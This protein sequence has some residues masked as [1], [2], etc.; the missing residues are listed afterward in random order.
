MPI[1][2]SDSLP[3]IEIL[4]N[5]NIFV[6]TETRAMTQDIRPLEIAV[7]N[8]MPTK[9]ETETQ[10]LRVLGN[11]PLQINVQFI[12]T[13]THVAR[14]TSKSHIETFYKTFDDIKDLKFDG[15]II[16]GAPVEMLDFEEVDY[17]DELCRIMEWSKENVTSTFHICWGAQAALYYHYGVPKHVVSE[18]VFGIFNHTIP[19]EKKHKILLRGFDDNFFVPHSRHTEVKKSDIEKVSSLE[20]LAE[21]EEAGVYIITDKNER[22][23]FI[24]GHSEYDSDTLQKEYLRDIERGLDIKVPKN[25][26]PDDDPT[27]EPIVKWRSHANLLYS[28]WLNYFV[29]QTTPY[30]IKEIR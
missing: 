18:K 10:L 27:K 20:I 19:S 16:T 9:I 28:N 4:N 15:L 7:L 25:Y 30:D 24:T 1:K 21:S 2:V 26:F 6:I 13:K 22:R 3:A 12:H 11:T 23:F 5:E 14:N 8:L 29:Y 17:W